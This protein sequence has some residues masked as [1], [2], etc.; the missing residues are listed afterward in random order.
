MRNLTFQ[1]IKQK[2]IVFLLVLF[3][4]ITSCNG[5]KKTDAVNSP[6]NDYRVL[7]ITIINSKE[8]IIKSMGSGWGANI[9][10]A[11]Q[12]KSGNLWFGTTGEGLYV[13]NGKSFVNYTTNNG[14]NR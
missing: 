4:T 11:L 6:V 9:C 10:S 7:S 1:F 14:L 8:K 2:Q 13:Y 3:S 5:Q 12:D